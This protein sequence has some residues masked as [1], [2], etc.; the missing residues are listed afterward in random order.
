MA[1]Q[2]AWRSGGRDSAAGN[3]RRTKNSDHVF[4]RVCICMLVCVYVCLHMWM[5][6]CEGDGGRLCVRYV[7]TVQINRFDLNYPLMHMIYTF[8]YQY[9]FQFFLQTTIPF[10]LS[11]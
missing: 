11:C 9:Q 10:R 6:V 7:H 8:Q 2:E 4:V 3:V 1:G 5:R